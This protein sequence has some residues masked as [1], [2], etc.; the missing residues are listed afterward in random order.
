[1]DAF[2]KAKGDPRDPKFGEQFRIDPNEMN[3]IFNKYLEMRHNES[4]LANKEA[5]DKFLAANK[6]KTGVQVTESGLQYIV[7]NPGNDSKAV[8]DQDTV[9]VRYKGTKLDG[10]VFDEVAPEADSVRFVLSRVVKGWTEGMKLV[11]EGGKIKLFVP[12]D[13]GY[14]ERAPQEIGPNQTLIFDVDICKVSRFVASE[15]EAEEKK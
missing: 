12:S 9:W 7:E 4:L 6:N 1:M 8:S 2:I 11:G 10:S 3:D 14:G 15:P 5:G 13:L